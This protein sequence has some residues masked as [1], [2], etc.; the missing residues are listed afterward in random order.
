MAQVVEL[1]SG[2]LKVL[3]SNSCAH[4]SA[5]THAQ[6]ESARGRDGVW[7]KALLTGPRKA[8]TSSA[9]RDTVTPWVPGP[10][11]AQ[12]WEGLA[13]AQEPQLSLIY[14]HGSLG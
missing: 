1:L 13:A 11:E 7:R 6:A 10:S 3:S 12:R 9:G 8:S 14:N 5:H 4:A 2:R